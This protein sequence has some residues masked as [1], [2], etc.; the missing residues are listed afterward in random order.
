MTQMS[1][2]P[3][4]RL[5]NARR[6]PSGDHAGETSPGPE[7]KGVRWPV[8]GSPSLSWFDELKVS[9]PLSPGN[10]A[11]AGDAVAAAITSAH[12]A[13]HLPAPIPGPPPPAG[14]A[15]ERICCMGI[16]QTGA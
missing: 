10:A 1:S 15:T 3:S 13:V 12:S 2:E 6:L 16:V 4:R 9:R 5:A 7:V 11:C 8:A 14:Y